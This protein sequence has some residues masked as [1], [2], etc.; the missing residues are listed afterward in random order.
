LDLEDKVSGP[1]RY[2]YNNLFRGGSLFVDPISS[3]TWVIKDNLF[4]QTTIIQSGQSIDHGNNGY[5]TNANRLQPTQPS[6]DQVLTSTN[7]DYRVGPL[8]RY[9]YPTNGGLLSRLIDAGSRNATNAALYHY[10]CITNQWKETNST[11]DIGWHVVAVTGAGAPIDSDYEG[12]P[13]HFEDASG[14]GAKNGSETLFT[15]ADTDGDARNDYQEYLE[16]TDPNNA[17][18][19]EKARLAYWRFNT[20]GAASV[21]ASEEGRLPLLAQNVTNVA[22]FDRGSLQM[23]NTNGSSILKYRQMETNGLVNFNPNR[24]SIRFWYN[25]FWQTKAESCRECCTNVAISYCSYLTNPVERADCESAQIEACLLECTN[26]CTGIGPGTWVRLFELGQW[27]SN[28]SVGHFALSIDPDGGKIVFQTQNGDGT[29]GGSITNLQG[30]ACYRLFASNVWHEIV[31]TYDNGECLL[32][33]NGYTV[34]LSPTNPPNILPPAAVISSG[35]TIGSST[36]GSLPCQG[37]IDELEIW[38]YPI[39]PAEIEQGQVV[40]SATPSVSPP[41][42]ELNWRREFNSSYYSLAL[43]PKTIY[44]RQ[45]PDTNWT[46]LA[47]NLTGLSYKDTNVIIGQRYE[48]DVLPT[49]RYLLSAINAPPIEYRGKV[50]LLV[51]Q[52]LTNALATN[53]TQLTEDLVGDGW[54]VIR[55]DAPRHDDVVWSNNPPK[56][57]TIKSWVSN[58]FLLDPTNTKCIFILGHVAVPHS[59]WNDPD[60]HGPRQLPADGYYGSPLTASW[61]DSLSNT[62]YVEDIGYYTNSAGD[63][64]FDQ[65]AFP[66]DASGLKI[67]LSVGRVDF[68]NMPTLTNGA[69]PR[70]EIEMLKQY[71]EKTHRYRRKLVPLRDALSVGVCQAV[72]PAGTY[73]TALRTGSRLFGLAPGVH[74]DGDPS[75]QALAFNPAPKSYL[76]G[77][78]SGHGADIWICAGVHR[79]DHLTNVLY[80]PFVEFYILSGSYFGDWNRANNFL[81]AVISTPNYGYASMYGF[82]IPWLHQP[83]ALGD[84]LGAGLNSTINSAVAYVY[85]GIMGDPT[86]RTHLTALP[87][88]L[89]AT[90]SGGG[91]TLTWV[92]S[93]ENPCQYSV[94]R[95]TNGIGGDFIRLTA[96]PILV[97]TFTDATPPA[98][99]KVYQVRTL[100]LVETGSGTFTNL[101]QGI[102]KT[103]N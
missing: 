55:H 53:L 24:C 37:L 48:Y 56:I 72:D 66:A 8:G 44:R 26:Q 70:S 15:G 25:P 74:V 51:D 52:T 38:N 79:T 32:M 5:V 65:S 30:A 75:F 77:V 34:A 11:V 14:D 78:Q 103:V 95:S 9:Y 16:G 41:S 92:P 7:L 84:I 63:G 33:M 67:Q 73:G 6:T 82:G 76:W 39:G 42:I 60:R 89:T 87:S 18:S 3:G 86:L 2:L 29:S 45:L 85:V 64:I 27:T 61:T 88:G 43:F 31:L 90:T 81:R 99:E 57:A 101:S 80:E 36:N 98:G 58:D 91:I 40:L 94:Y 68:A 21:W 83:L 10:T 97:P 35:F 4:D 102:F 19:Y 17:F 93:S 46:L 20:N 62:G 13:D 47:S 69:P 54:K 1:T 100:K 59:G 71:L 23:N 12:L 28:N 49:E 96:Q 50:I 22:G